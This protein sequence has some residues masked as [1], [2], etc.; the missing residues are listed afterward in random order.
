[1][2]KAVGNE[3]ET[4]LHHFREAY[5][6]FHS[7]GDPKPLSLAKFGLG[8][9]YVCSFEP[10]KAEPLLEEALP[11]LIK[12]DMKREIGLTRHFHADCSLVRKDYS[13]SLH[14]YK[15]AL[16]AILEAKDSLQMCMELLGIAMS[17]AGK[18]FFKDAI[19]LNAVVVHFMN[20]QFGFSE[21]KVDFWMQ[22]IEETIGKAKQEVGAELTRQYEK[23]GISMG[24]EK[25]VEYALDFELV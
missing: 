16:K 25:A 18:S 21:V 4:A 10:D 2:E 9:G 3:V 24:L 20:K 1:M 13:E 17:L 7:L 5:S 15:I 19:M 11:A 8:F 14:R 23:E 22:S 12:F 6:I